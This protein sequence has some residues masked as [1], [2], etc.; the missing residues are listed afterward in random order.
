MNLNRTLTGDCRKIIPKLQDRSI[1]CIVTS[2]PYYKKIDYEH[3]DQ[4]GQEKTDDTYIAEL[5][6]VFELCK[7]KLV[8]TATI[9][10]NIG[11]SY[12]DGVLLQIPERFSIAMQK[13]GWKLRNDIIWARDRSMPNVG[14]GKRLSVTH[15]HVYFFTLHNEYFFDPLYAEFASSDKQTLKAVASLHLP[16]DVTIYSR[17]KGSV[18]HII[19]AHTGNAHFAPFPRELVRYC[20]TA[21]CPRYICHNCHLPQYR[22]Y[23]IYKIPTRTGK[24]KKFGKKSGTD[25]DPNQTFHA[26]RRSTLR[27]L[28]LRVPNGYTKCDC[29]ASVTHGLVFDPF[30]GSGTTALE[31]YAQEMNFIIIELNPNYSNETK[32]LLSHNLSMRLDDF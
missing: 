21:G 15:E 12:N 8:S 19:N 20:I 29:N 18:W 24:G 27:E 22:S 10:I 23:L 9:W 13:N 11:D 2:P 28:V 17:V 26:S 32:K 25:K 7:P 1:H 30:G 16:P 3:P 6:H 4:I 5:V 14:N 31:A